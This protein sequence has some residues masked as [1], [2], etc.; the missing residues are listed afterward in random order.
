AD[1]HG[2]GRE[3]F[4]G[5]VTL[6]DEAVRLRNCSVSSEVSR[7]TILGRERPVHAVELGVAVNM[8]E[9]IRVVLTAHRLPPW[10]L[11]DGDRYEVTVA[12][13]PLKVSMDGLSP[14]LVVQLQGLIDALPPGTLV[15][16]R[17]LNALQ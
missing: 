9:P 16:P 11:Q 6:S 14:P 13:G 7:C 12:T 15:V 10:V 1:L 8:G 2:G 17:P 4:C 3:Q 5:T